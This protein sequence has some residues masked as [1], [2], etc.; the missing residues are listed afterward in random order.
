MKV[1]FLAITMLFIAVI[2]G[3]A[4]AQPDETV[5]A[6]LRLD[7]LVVLS[8]QRLGDEALIA[9]IGQ[10]GVAFV[11]SPQDFEQQRAAGVS[12]GVL[13]Y[14][15]GRASGERGLK[16]Q[17][18]SGR[19]RVPAD[20]GTLHLG[21]PYL[22]YHGG[23]HYYCGHYYG[24]QQYSSGTG[25]TLAPTTAAITATIIERVQAAEASACFENL[26]QQPPKQR[27]SRRDKAGCEHADGVTEHSRASL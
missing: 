17:I 10:R 4:P 26:G 16:A 6:R 25:A 15:Q 7:E 13:R 9:Q 19:Y 2:S 27:D 20:S 22:G 1:S 23:H 5:A 12:E 8:G 3:C 11:L 14:L 18:V 24:G 21:Y